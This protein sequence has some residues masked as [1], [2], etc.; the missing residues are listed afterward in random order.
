MS[1]SEQDRRVT[2]DQARALS[3][4]AKSLSYRGSAV[5]LGAASPT[6]VYHLI[7]RLGRALH[8]F[9]LVSSSTRGRVELTSI[10]QEVLPRIEAFIAA[11]DALQVERAEIRFCA[12]PSIAGRAIPAVV[13]FLERHSDLD[14]IFHEISDQSRHDRGRGIVER[15]L[16]GEIDISV[17]PA[18]YGQ[19]GLKEVP[20]YSWRLRALLSPHDERSR[21]DTIQIDDL[22]D[23]RILVA[24]E[25]HYSR[26]LFDLASANAL[27]KPEI[28]M[29]VADHGLMRNL[30]SAA[31][32]YVAII[33][34][35][36][37][38]LESFVGPSLVDSDGGELGGSYSLYLS[39][40]VASPIQE[41]TS[42][43]NRSEA[44]AILAELLR[45]HLGNSTEN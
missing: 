13:D 37:F 19:S 32:G 30:A 3:S 45:I 24:P 27:S 41:S 38:G 44:V 14:V 9:P 1:G 8:R 43:Q 4:V 29:Q 6:S 12:Y 35:D 22:A 26:H 15:T 21:R 11:H 7:E 36:A 5:E 28:A 2:I 42:L 33:P 40:R 25:G 18:G 23:L 39:S 20:L 16:R 10:G 31:R 34:D 17:V